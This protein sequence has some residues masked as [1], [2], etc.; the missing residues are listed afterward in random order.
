MTEQYIGRT[1]A[2]WA[3]LVKRTDVKSV[4]DGLPVSLGFHDSIGS[5]ITQRNI[6]VTIIKFRRRQWSAPY[7]SKSETIRPDTRP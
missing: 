5:H 4:F 3:E 2:D 7:Q 1:E 6:T